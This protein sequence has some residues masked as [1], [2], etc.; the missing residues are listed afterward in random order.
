MD[1]NQFLN[2]LVTIAI[3]IFPDSDCEKSIKCLLN[4]YILS[5]EEKISGERIEKNKNLVQ[6]LD[7]ANDKN[8]MMVLEIVKKSLSPFFKYYTAHKEYLCFASFMK[9]CSDFEIFPQTC[10]KQFIVKLFHMLANMQLAKPI[11]REKPN[12]S[13]DEE[14][15]VQGIAICAME[16]VYLPADPPKDEKVKY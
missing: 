7:M 10:S 11:K 4:E 14:L 8:M 13:I 16:I 6:I 15:F 12:Q 3:R 1:F 2:S 5:L 9:F